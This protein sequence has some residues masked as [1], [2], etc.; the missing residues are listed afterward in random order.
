MSN[1]PTIYN[2]DADLII[3]DEN[4]YLYILNF[5]WENQNQNQ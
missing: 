5:I 2:Q 1:M 3:D 4:V